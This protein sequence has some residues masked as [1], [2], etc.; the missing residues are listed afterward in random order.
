MAAQIHISVTIML[1]ASLIR[2]I[3]KAAGRFAGANQG[4]IA[5]IFAIALVPII[6]FVGAA[7]DYS[8]AVKAKSSMQAA[9]DSTVLM[10]SKDLSQNLITADQVNAKGQ[11]YFAALYTNNETN[12][13]TVSASYSVNGGL[14]SS[15]QMTGSGSINTDFMK[16]AGF[17]NLGFSTNSTSAWGNTRMRV[18]MVLDN[19]GSMADNGKMGALQTAAK[20]MVDTLSGFNTQTGDV[21][22]SIIP[23]A[24]DVNVDTA[25]ASQS[26]LNWREWEA[27]PPYL[28]QNGYPSSWSA[29]T[30][31][32]NCP[33]TNNS[34]GFT[35][36]D[37]PATL[38]GARSASSIPS[39][40]QYAGYIC[41]SV[42]SG[43]MIP[44]KTGIFDNGC[45][46]TNTIAGQ[47][48]ATGSGASCGSTSNCSCSGSGSHKICQ[49]A[50]TYTH[51]WRGATAATPDH[52]TWTGCVNDRDQDY[53]TMNTAPTTGT[54]TPSTQFY[55]EQWTD[56]L[57]ATV[58][59][60]SNQW[61][62]LKTQID[63]MSPSGNTNQAV[64]L[65]WGWLSL[66]TTNPP[67]RRIE[68]PEPL[69]HHPV[70]H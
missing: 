60:M 32:S 37:R 27:E 23:F 30:A 18:A 3:R 26:W 42:D 45:Y 58:T 21:Y 5:V 14:G 29:T 12:A 54:A 47:T 33:F 34:Q 17:P 28:V 52:T 53:D 36:M 38:S 24:K 59:G 65:A 10:L 44:G 66:S 6:S 43:K 2:R 41:P 19:T 16:V 1:G 15:I 4:N 39:S 70:R 63:G 55:A 8:R 9:L 64:G 68:Y 7:I 51:T 11:A 46:T 57:P 13:V 69:E 31:G 67:V 22:I 50:T 62:T 25:N 48:I 56:C 40:G 35:C 49:T 61:S 20:N